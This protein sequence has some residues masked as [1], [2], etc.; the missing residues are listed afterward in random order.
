[1]SEKYY[2]LDGKR[3]E[4]RKVTLVLCATEEK[5]NE[6]PYIYIE[7]RSFSMHEEIV[8]HIML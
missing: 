3:R 7:G 5:G 4:E 6:H 1:M 8:K 2:S